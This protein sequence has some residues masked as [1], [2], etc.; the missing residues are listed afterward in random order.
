MNTTNKDLEFI[1][2]AKEITNAQ[3]QLVKETTL[4]KQEVD[5][6]GNSQTVLSKEQKKQFLITKIRQDSKR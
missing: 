5:E 4:Y 6:A 1:E 3:G 2:K